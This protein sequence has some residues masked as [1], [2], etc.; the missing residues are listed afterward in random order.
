MKIGGLYFI[1]DEFYS[2]YG[3][4]GLLGNK[5]N[6]HKRPCCYAFKIHKD[7]DM[8]WMIPVSSRI[9]KYEEIYKHSME[10]YGKCDNIEFGYVRGHKNA[11]LPQNMFPVLEKYVENP[12][13][14]I[15][16]NK[17]IVMPKEFIARLNAKARKKYKYNFAGKKLGMSDI[18]SI[19]NSLLL[20]K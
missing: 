15:N 6:G 2:K 5:E 19:Y 13:L 18:V 11:F 9:D 16:T 4:Y 12:Y 14:D 1:K 17:H 3:K 8:Y 7:D 10:K 20:E